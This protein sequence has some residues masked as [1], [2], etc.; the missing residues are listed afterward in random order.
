M[1]ESGSAV[2]LMDGRDHETEGSE[3]KVTEDVAADDAPLVTEPIVTPVPEATVEVVAAGAEDNT[4]ADAATE[5][6]AVLEE[7]T[8]DAEADEETA[9]TWRA[10]WAA[11]SWPWYDA[12][13]RGS[14]TAPTTAN[15]MFGGRL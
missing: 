9:G 10:K 11:C 14:A 5:L 13:T 12:A 8:A 3:L 15:F 2:G 7:V 1:S 6:A 4:D